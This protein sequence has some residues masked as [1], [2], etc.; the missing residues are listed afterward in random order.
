V[1]YEL[2]TTDD[3]LQALDTA[4]NV[5]AHMCQDYIDEA[6]SAES[7]QAQEV[8]RS[9]AQDSLICLSTLRYLHMNLAYQHQYGEP[10]PVPKNR[11]ELDKWAAGD[12]GTGEVAA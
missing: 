11:A 7:D 9:D 5:I 2:P 4:I 8:A 3:V 12:F 6:E 1:D 10:M